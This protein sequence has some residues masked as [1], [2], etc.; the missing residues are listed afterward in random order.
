MHRKLFFDAFLCGLPYRVAIMKKLL[1]TLILIFSFS[2]N[3][4]AAND[5][6][7]P[8]DLTVTPLRIFFA[9]LVVIGF[10]IAEILFEKIREQRVASRPERYEKKMAELA[11]KRKKKNKGE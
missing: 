11:E 1:L 9:V 4:F 7:I 3:S 2:V 10:I 5:N 8:N 6:R